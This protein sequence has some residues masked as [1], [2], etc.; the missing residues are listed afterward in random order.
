MKLTTELSKIISV[1]KLYMNTGGFQRNRPSKDINY[2]K[3]TMLLSV[4]HINIFV[5]P[6]KSNTHQDAKILK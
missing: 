4:S 1:I 3:I 6:Q 2:D 5:H